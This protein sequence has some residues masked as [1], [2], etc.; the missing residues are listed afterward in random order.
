MAIRK[1]LSGTLT[2]YLKVLTYDELE[3]KWFCECLRCGRTFKIKVGVVFTQKSCG[4]LLGAKSGCTVTHGLYGK[5]PKLYDV[6]RHMISRCYNSKDKAYKNYG[7]RG[8]TVCDEWRN[9]ET[10][11]TNFFDWA[12]NNNYESTLELD[13]KDNNLGYSPENCHFITRQENCRNRRSNR[14]ILISGE[15]ITLTEAAERFTIVTYS[16]ILRRIHRKG[17]DIYDALFT[18]PRCPPVSGRDYNFTEKEKVR[19]REALKRFI[20]CIHPTEPRRSELQS[21]L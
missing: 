20:T 15:W 12:Y 4:C 3:K 2:K 16:V 5:N 21:G 11:L 1:D 9:K 8:I 13:R 17:W 19:Y 7:A 10:G 18:P 6:H 14:K